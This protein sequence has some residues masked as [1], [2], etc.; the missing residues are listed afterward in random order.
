MGDSTEPV[1]QVLQAVG[2]GEEH[3]AEKLLPLVYRCSQALL[4][5]LVIRF[6]VK[7]GTI[8]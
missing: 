2:A 5:V 1:M 7:P 3:A 6:G 4:V 8:G